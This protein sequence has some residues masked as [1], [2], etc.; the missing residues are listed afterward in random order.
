MASRR[1]WGAQGL[2]AG[3]RTAGTPDTEATPGRG[4]TV[5]AL[6]HGGD[7]G[8]A[9]PVFINQ[10]MLRE[11][12]REIGAAED[13]QVLAGLL[14]QS[15]DFLLGVLFDQPRI[16]PFGSRAFVKRRS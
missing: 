4:R 10:A 11:R 2:L 1:L 8:G 9:E 13:E 16:V 12:R 6:P 14:L 15:R 7:G 5:P 3:L